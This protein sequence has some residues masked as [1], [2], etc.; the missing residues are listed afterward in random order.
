M[1]HYALVLVVI[2]VIVGCFVFR[3]FCYRCLRKARNKKEMVIQSLI[4]AHWFLQQRVEAEKLQVTLDIFK[5][6]ECLI[7]FF[8][9]ELA[10]LTII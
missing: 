10:I 4:T 9:C 3:F 6:S 1:C 7:D 5:V 2:R 8:H